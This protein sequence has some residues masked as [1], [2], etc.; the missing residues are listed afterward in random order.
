[1]NRHAEW[2]RLQYDW[3]VASRMQNEIV[4]ITPFASVSGAKTGRILDAR[5][6]DEG[7]A[8][9]YV[10]EYTFPMVTRHSSERASNNVVRLSGTR[11]LIDLRVDAS[12][13]LSTPLV[14]ILGT[15]RPFSPHVHPLTGTVC[16]GELW[17]ESAG[18]MLVGELVVHV[19]AHPELRRTRPGREP[20]WVRRGWDPVLA[21]SAE[22]PAA[23]PRSAVPGRA[24]ARGVRH[25]SRPHASDEPARRDPSGAHAEGDVKRVLRGVRHERVPEKLDRTVATPEDRVFRAVDGFEVRISE[26]IVLR[27]CA[28]ARDAEPDEWM[29]LLAV[30][31]FVDNLGRT[32]ASSASFRIRASKPRPRGSPRRPPRRRSRASA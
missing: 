14:Q 32:C 9:T 30:R 24:G 4:R 28:F 27:L 17:K 5:L 6:A 23:Q 11:A 19:A 12:Y 7:H 10:A 13:P 29:G 16:L 21:G 26:E 20:R 2:R 31:K 22:G 3:R 25:R 15:P 8:T 1:V 18:S